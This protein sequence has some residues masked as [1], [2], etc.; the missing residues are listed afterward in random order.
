MYDIFVDEKG[1]T[2]DNVEVNFHDTL[3]DLFEQEDLDRE[4]YERENEANSDFEVSDD[5]DF[6]VGSW[7]EEE[8]REELEEIR[9]K[10]QN[11]KAHLKEGLLNIATYVELGNEGFEDDGFASDDSGYY[12]TTDEDDE[13]A[14]HGVRIPNPLP[15]YN[16]RT[17][18]PY[19]CHGMTFRDI[20]EVREALKKHAVKDRRD[21][22]VTK[23]DPYRVRARCTGKGCTWTFFVSYNKRFKT[24][25]L[26]TYTEHSCSEHF[27]NKFVSPRF[28]ANHY[29][30]RIRSNPRWKI[31]DMRETIREDFGTDVSLMQCSKAKSIITHKSLASYTEEYAL[32]R[33]YAEQL[34]RGLVPSIAEMFPEA[35]HRLCARHIYQ[36]WRKKFC[37]KKWQKMFWECAKSSTE[38]QFNRNLARIRL[39]NP[40]AAESMVRIDPKY[41]CRAW[42]STDVKCDSVDNNL[43]ESF[44]S[45]ILEPRHKPI[46]SMLEDIRIQC[47]ENI[48][49]K[50][51]K[52]NRWQGEDPEMF[53]ADCYSI[54][55]YCKTYDHVMQ[56]LDG[57]KEWPHSE[58]EAILPPIFRAMPGR[59]R[60]KRVRGADEKGG[61][62]RKRKVY[63]AAE[64]LNR[65]KNNHSKLSRVGRVMSCKSCGKDGHNIRTCKDKNANQQGQSGATNSVQSTRV[66]GGG[67]TGRG[68]GVTARGGTWRGDTTRGLSRGRKP[69]TTSEV[70]IAQGSNAD[71]A[72]G[73]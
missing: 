1:G 48:T 66:R 28:I 45:L 12:V 35:E 22:R 36:N 32:L 61:Y 41:W 30:R 4:A 47:M 43:S 49:I 20:M 39:S 56:P 59:P 16:P 72:Y 13:V 60:K 50:R 62:K 55:N 7:I 67:R 73:D 53:L 57:P 44:N 25:Q 21:I 2:K 52:A 64:L 10:V 63:T 51:D 26:K 14:D 69:G 37:D 5:S 8:D 40:S 46:F 19:F 23:S 38:V 70:V 31:K 15:K 3:E 18:I 68:R 27:K 42:F 11:S 54:E 17:V 6:E 65:D 33:T 29:M 24:F 34:L 71:G 58:Y 9:K